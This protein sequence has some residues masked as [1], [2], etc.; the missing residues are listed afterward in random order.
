MS[1]QHRLATRADLPRIVAIYNSTVASRMVTADLEPVSVESRESW[2]AE[3]QPERRPLWVVERDDAIA[4]WLSFS[5][6]YGR[7]AYGRTAELSI[8]L[9]EAVRG[10][11]LGRHLLQLAIDAAPGVGLDTLLGFIFGHNQASLALFERFGFARWG[12]LPRV[13]VLDGVERDLIIVGRRLT[14]A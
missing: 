1:W 11:G 9:D 7:P 13:A 6:F 12:E 8:Y 14:D 10:Q 5:D 3:H 2:F 4:G